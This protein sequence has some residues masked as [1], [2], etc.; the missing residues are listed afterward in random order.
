MRIVC[1]ITVLLI[2]APPATYAAD[3]SVR[4]P[5]IRATLPVADQP[6]VVI[7][8]GHVST[9]PSLAGERIALNIDADLSDLQQKI[10]PIL[11]AQLNQDNRC[12]DR[13]S[14]DRA[15]LVPQPPAS[16]LTAYVHYEKWACAKALGKEIVKKLVAG[17]GVITVRLTAVVDAPDT[18]HLGAD[19]VSMDASGQLAEILHSG[20][21]GS[22]L[23]EK[24]RKKLVSELGKS[25]NLKA[26]LPSALQSVAAV[27]T[28]EFSN[29]GEGRLWLAISGEVEVSAEQAAALAGQLKT[30]A[31]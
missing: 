25:A 1:L 11:R 2:C 22:A 23:Q 5:P 31:R 6:V 27:K 20:S 9:S 10:T 29:G 7:V 24:I 30:L 13:M 14:V 15:T 19:V 12:G 17:D 4:I 3:L 21:F 26:T 8:S 28:A 18:V 16:L